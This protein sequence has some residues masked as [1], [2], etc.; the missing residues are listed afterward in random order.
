MRVSLK[1]PIIELR[2]L[3]DV[4][5]RLMFDK[6]FSKRLLDQKV[7]VVSR[8]RNTRFDLNGMR[9]VDLWLPGDKENKEEQA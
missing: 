1:K 6:H 9:V 2:Q 8:Y 5:I 4:E 3:S 7:F